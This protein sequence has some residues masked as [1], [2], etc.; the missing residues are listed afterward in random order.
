MPYTDQIIEEVNI[1]ARYNLD[2]SQEGIK[3]HSSAE[4]DVIEATERLF[5]KGLVSQQDGGYLTSLGRDA[6]EHAQNL[7]FILNSN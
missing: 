4:S 2:T 1:L 6:A 3:V 7:L 5:N